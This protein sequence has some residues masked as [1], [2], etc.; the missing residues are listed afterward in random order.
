MW[1]CSSTM[2]VIS[3]LPISTNE[4]PRLLVSLL[5]MEI[6][7]LHRVKVALLREA[8][9][10]CAM[11]ILASLDG[12]VRD[13]TR[14]GSHVTESFTNGSFNGNNPIL[15]TTSE[16]R[17]FGAAKEKNSSTLGIEQFN[18]CPNRRNCNT[19]CHWCRSK[20]TRAH[21]ILLKK[22]QRPTGSDDAGRVPWS[23]RRHATESHA[24]LD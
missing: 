9:S 4:Q 14:I 17:H 1:T 23:Q 2:T 8:A 13:A 11:A 18:K 16:V 15:E 24:C 21:S 10:S 20:Q 5:S 22:E 12:P 3:K 7:M 19:G 6:P